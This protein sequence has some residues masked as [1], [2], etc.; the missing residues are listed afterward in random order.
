M[1]G[2]VSMKFASN[3]YSSYE[4]VETNAATAGYP[5][6]ARH[7]AAIGTV[8]SILATLREVEKLS[9]L[10]MYITTMANDARKGAK[11]TNSVFLL[12]HNIDMLLVEFRSVGA[13]YSYMLEVWRN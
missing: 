11:I 10:D 6:S 9:V 2:I 5:F 13:H 1:V 4:E 7:E 8:R 12:A 3:R